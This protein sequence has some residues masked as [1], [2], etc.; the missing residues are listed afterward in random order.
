M[1]QANNIIIIAALQQNRYPK[2]MPSDLVAIREIAEI[3]GVTTQR[4]SRI[5]Q[6]HPDF[7]PAEAELSIGKVWLRPAVEEWARRWNRAP[8]RRQTAR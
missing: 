5:I 4:V 7:P 2:V 8:G 6:T 1:D 3:L